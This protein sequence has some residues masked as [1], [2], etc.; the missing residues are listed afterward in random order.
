MLRGMSAAA[1]VLAGCGD[2][3]GGHVQQDEFQSKIVHAL[4]DSV[5]NC[6]RQANRGFDAVHCRQTVIQQFVVPLT[7]T[8]LLYDSAQAGRCVNA[9][10]QAAQACQSVDVTTCFDAFIGNLPPGS[11]CRTSFECAPGPSGYAVCGQDGTCSQPPRGVPGQSCAYSC[12]EDGGMPKCRS[13]FYGVAAV[14]QAACHSQDGL[15]C[16]AGTTGTGTCQP[17]WADC[18]QNPAQSCPAGQFCDVATSKCFMPTPVGGACSPGVAL[19]GSDGYCAGGLC[20]AVRPNATVCDNDIECAS[21]KCETGF[22]V[23][24]SKAASEWCGE[25]N[26]L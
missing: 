16:V 26:P 1:A 10:T 18:K 15:V 21:G 14:T 11:A 25:I 4:C 12:I 2:P 24:Y 23:V 17:L 7:D 13:V 8:S 19:C 22:C 9:V 6:C 3:N 20:Y 5:Q